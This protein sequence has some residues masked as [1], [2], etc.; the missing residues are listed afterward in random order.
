VLRDGK[1]RLRGWNESD[2]FVV[3]VSLDGLHGDF[4]KLMLEVRDTRDLI[5]TY[6]LYE[7]ALS[8]DELAA[9]ATDGGLGAVRNEGNRRESMEKVWM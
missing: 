2:Q 7:S 4:G 8:F 1:Y 5:K 3:L 6:L 9:L